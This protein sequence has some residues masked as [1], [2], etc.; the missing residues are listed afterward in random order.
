LLLKETANPATGAACVRLTVQEV[1]PGVLI[2]ALVHVNP[3]S[4]GEAVRLRIK[5]LFT[6][7]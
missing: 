6:L 7:A 3:L 1:L 2:V 4:W 5:A